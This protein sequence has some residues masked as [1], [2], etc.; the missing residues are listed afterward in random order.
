M[1]LQE[2]DREIR[3][4]KGSEN[5]VAD[6]LSRILY[7]RESES[8]VSECFP[9]EQLCAV[10]SDPWY[11]DIVNYLVTGRIPESWTKN[12]RD[13]FFHLVKFFVWDGPYLFKYCY[14]QMFRRCIPDH[15]VKSVISF[16]MIK[17]MGGILVG[18]R[19]QLEFFNMVYI[20]CF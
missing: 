13:R 8:T 7:D 2:S 20:G 6:H 16:V 14:D 5:L 10:H 18:E 9:D 4:K 12:D 17:H 11:A 15:E 19:L 1:L 3:D